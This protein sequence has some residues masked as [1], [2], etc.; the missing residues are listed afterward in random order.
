MILHPVRGSR[1]VAQCE[2]IYNV[3]DTSWQRMITRVQVQVNTP[4]TMLSVLY[5]QSTPRHSPTIFRLSASSPSLSSPSSITESNQHL[6]DQYNWKRRVAK[7]FN[8]HREGPYLAHR[9]LKPPITLPSNAPTRSLLCN[10]REVSLWALESSTSSGS[11]T[12]GTNYFQDDRYR[13]Q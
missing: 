4:R 10:L 5:L 9:F 6:L 11:G 7:R 12:G 13:R 1:R 3:K 2:N 8:N